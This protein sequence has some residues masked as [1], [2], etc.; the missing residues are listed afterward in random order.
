MEVFID[1]EFNGYRGQLITM[2]LVAMDG[3]EMYASVPI[4]ESSVAPWVADNVMPIISAGVETPDRMRH[5]DLPHEIAAFLSQYDSVHLIADWPD[6]V[7]FFCEYLITGPGYRVD[8]PPLTMEIRRD[9]D[10]DSTVPHHALHDARGIRDLYL[11]LV[12]DA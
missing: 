9:L 7:R 2:A 3:R 11:S 10:A 12:A 8:T 1:C 4:E 6:D 5:E